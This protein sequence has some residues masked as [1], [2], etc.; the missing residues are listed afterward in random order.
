MDAVATDLPSAL[1]L[2]KGGRLRALGIVFPQRV[3]SLPSVPTMV[4][5][6]QPEVDIAPF[7]ALMAPRDVSDSVVERLTKTNSAVLADAAVR[8]RVEDVGGIPADMSRPEFEKFLKHQVRT[9]G[10][11][12]GSGL[13]KTE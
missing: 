3:A 9:Y 1:Q 8:R 4:E 13:L 10:D 7:T 5:L 11:L 12:I 6:D 2:V